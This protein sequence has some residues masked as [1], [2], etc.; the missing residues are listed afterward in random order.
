MGKQQA[1]PIHQKNGADLR[2]V[3]RM[4]SDKF[5]QVRVVFPADA[6]MGPDVINGVLKDR[7][8]LVQSPFGMLPEGSGIATGLQIGG[9]DG[10]AVFGHRL[11]DRKA[12]REKNN[13]SY[14]NADVAFDRPIIR[15]LIRNNRC[16]GVLVSWKW[17]V[18]TL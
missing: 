14:N 12:N 18:A 3:A 7:I 1:L 5:P 4:E 11:P 2:C 17:Q 10:Q 6:A 9:P 8:G 15:Y 16:H 13:Q